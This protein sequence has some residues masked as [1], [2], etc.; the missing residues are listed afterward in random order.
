ME[1]ISV[2]LIIRLLDHNY[3][4]VNSVDSNY[5]P[6]LVIGPLSDFV[7][8]KLN[9]DF[10]SEFERCKLLPM[11]CSEETLEKNLNNNIY[12]DYRRRGSI[13]ECTTVQAIK[14]VKD[15]KRHG[16]LDISIT[17][18]ERLHRLQI[19]PIV[20]LL[21]FRS[22]KQ[23]KEVKDSRYSTDKISAKAAKEM[24]EQAVKLE[25]EIGHLISGE[26][27]GGFVCLF[28]CHL[29]NWEFSNMAADYFD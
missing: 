8:D 28:L 6:I 1:L 25:S 20:L 23:I 15:K 13:F 4:L 27:R 17:A 11:N 10:P 21:R 14:E 29:S 22:A 12:V 9:A 5:R 3:F 7:V 2:L 16:C 26:R 19:Y 24:Y 18:I